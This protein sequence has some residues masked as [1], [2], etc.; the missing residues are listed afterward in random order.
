MALSKILKSIDDLS[1][2]IKQHY[3]KRGDKYV[4]DIDGDDDTT[5]LRNAKDREKERADAEAQRR[6]EAEKVANELQ[7]KVADLE[8]NPEVEKL[9]TALEES[10]TKFGKLTGQLSNTTKAT[11]AQRIASE[12]SKSPKLLSRFI[13]DR[14]SVELDENYQPVIKPLGPDLKTADN[15]SLDDL[16]K[17]FAENKDFADIIIASKASGGG[18]PRGGSPGQSERGA[19]SKQQQNDAPLLS[20]IS[21][22]DLAAHLKAK[23][24]NGA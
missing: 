24:E 11:E 16:K 2:D 5:A 20:Q 18:A 15:F 10:E 8:A 3:T 13:E 4:L 23:K 22:Q 9:K 12:I 1:D 19:F 7:S 21:P 17:E 14:L 6:R